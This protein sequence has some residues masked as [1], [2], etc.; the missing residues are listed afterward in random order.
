MSARTIN[1]GDEMAKITEEMKEVFAKAQMPM[2]STASRTATPN[3]VPIN[4]TRVFSD[5]E[6]LLMDNFMNKTR[7]N[8]ENNPQ[9]AISVWA[10]DMRKGFQ[11]KGQARIEK[12]GTI[13]EE[14]AKWVKSKAPKMAPR[15]AIIV[16]IDEIYLINPG[17]DA[18]KRVA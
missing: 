11:F 16:T 12:D 14:G 9:V 17:P 8:I 2:I 7:T 13:F 4:F 18:G 15:A 1:K 5:N 3:V 6:I 10:P